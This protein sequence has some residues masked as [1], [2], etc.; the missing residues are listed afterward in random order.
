MEKQGISDSR[1]QQNTTKVVEM[2]GDAWMKYPEY[3]SPFELV[4]SDITT[5]VAKNIDEMSWQAVQRVGINADKEKL[6]SALNQDA[7]R[8]REAYKKGYETGYTR[9]DEEI[10]RCEDCWRYTEYGNSPLCTGGTLTK[11]RDWFCANGERR[12]DDD[13]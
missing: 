2:V 6:L 8:Y 9:R 3:D 10:I 5:Q 12:D 1:G 4:L 11:G 13:E 7:E